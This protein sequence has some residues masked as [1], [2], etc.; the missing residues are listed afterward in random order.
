MRQPAIAAAAGVIAGCAVA[1]PHDD[2]W[3]AG[4]PPK[5][6]FTRSWESD[7]EN[8]KLQTLEQYLHWVRK[9]YEGTPIAPGWT[10]AS[11]RLLEN[12]P[13]EARSR[14]KPRLAELGALIC[15]DW[16]KDN[17]RR[18]IDN[19]MLAV[20]GAAMRNAG[21][22]GRVEAALD[23][24]A[25]DARAVR[26]GTLPPEQVTSERYTGVALARQSSVP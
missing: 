18:R 22:T 23:L 10:A 5:H 3:P 14:I 11:R 24:I 8:A 6:H 4:Q 21:P 9:F 15:A 17:R 7:A 2:D 25:A 13:E 20:W 26:E 1:R 19:R 12:R 16:A